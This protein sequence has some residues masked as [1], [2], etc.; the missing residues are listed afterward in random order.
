[1]IR[2]KTGKTL[3]VALVVVAATIAFA[4]VAMAGPDK[5]ETARGAA[6][7]GEQES[8]ADSSEL[9]ALLAR[10]LAA[11]QEREADEA[12][13]AGTVGGLAEFFAPGL[14][15]AAGSYTELR[16]AA[17]RSDGGLADFSAPRLS[18]AA[19]SYTELRLAAAGP[20]EGVVEVFARSFTALQDR[21]ADEAAAGETCG[22]C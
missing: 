3:F 21:E 15:D 19:G 9:A 20:D 10:N 5:G 6:Y 13:A 2:M 18:D 1:M 11:V 16:L 8:A 14:S 12:A 4:G 17:A 7:A 22:V